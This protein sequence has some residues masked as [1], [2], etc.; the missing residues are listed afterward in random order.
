M[1]RS[2]PYG[3]RAAVGIGAEILYLL[4]V[5]ARE[6]CVVGLDW[7]RAIRYSHCSTSMCSFI[8]LIRSQPQDFL[9]EQPADLRGNSSSAGLLL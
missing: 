5:A 6:C 8:F 9:V 3:V 2:G 4:I 1:T 7:L